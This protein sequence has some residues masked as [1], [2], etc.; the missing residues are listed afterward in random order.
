MTLFFLDDS[1]RGS[2]INSQTNIRIIPNPSLKDDIDFENENS[3]KDFFSESDNQNRM[4]YKFQP[5]TSFNCS[6]LPPA[7]PSR[8]HIPS[9]YS[10]YNK[11]PPIPPHRNLN[12]TR[13][14]RSHQPPP[15]P[16]HQNINLRRND[17]CK[18]VTTKQLIKSN[19]NSLDNINANQLTKYL[20]NSKETNA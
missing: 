14:L 16:P 19:K 3:E 18:S 17:R 20:D 15:V 5:P 6:P 9:R 1:N 11:P 4:S 13:H 8:R 2:F 10:S 12:Q 7:V